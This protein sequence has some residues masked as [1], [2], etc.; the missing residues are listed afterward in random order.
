M[1]CYVWS[2]KDTFYRN[3]QFILNRPPFVDTYVEHGYFSDD[4]TYVTYDMYDLRSITNNVIDAFVKR[5][6]DK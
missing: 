5:L 1:V 3:G 6:I 2:Y 4:M